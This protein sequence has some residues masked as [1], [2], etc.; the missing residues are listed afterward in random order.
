ME[1]D[2]IRKNNQRIYQVNFGN[3]NKLRQYIYQLRLT[4]DNGVLKTLKRDL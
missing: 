1:T 4:I 2:H 3:I